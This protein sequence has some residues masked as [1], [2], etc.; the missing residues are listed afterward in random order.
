MAYNGTQFLHENVEK[1][2]GY[3]KIFLMQICR[4]M[5][6]YQYMREIVFCENYSW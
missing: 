5:T 2:I 3:S 4:V 1:N 6:F